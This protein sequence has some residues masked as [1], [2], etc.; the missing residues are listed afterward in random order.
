VFD[1]LL[2]EIKRLE[3]NKTE[4]SL[5]LDDDGYLDRECPNEDCE[6]QF[7]I[8]AEDWK[9]ICRDEEVFCPLCRHSAPAKSWFTKQQEDKINQTVQSVF[10][11]A[12]R[13]GMKADADQ[14]NRRQ[15]SNSFIKITMSV[16]SSA[17]PILL[18]ISAAEPMRQK[19]A[20]TQ[21]ECRY[22]Y[23]GSAFFC[24]SC[25]ENSAEQ[26]FAQSLESIRVAVSS[27]DKIRSVMDRDDAEVAIRLLREKGINDAVMAFQRLAERLYARVPGAQPARRNVFQRLD[28]GAGLWVSTGL[29]PYSDF[30]TAAELGRL[31]IYFQQRHLLSHCEGIVDAD[32]VG[33]SGDQSYQIG[34]HLLISRDAVIELVQLVEKLGNELIGPV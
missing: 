27:D 12:I 29:K 31:K 20:C 34:Q 13:R 11:G 21:C 17:P 7:K 23:I 10:G 2:R 18:P 8:H 25:G 4:V 28:E 26:T 6:F 22:S 19:T 15:S 9:K 14:W 33:R 32:Y 16:Q 3:Q 30:L 24:P 1:N 5:P